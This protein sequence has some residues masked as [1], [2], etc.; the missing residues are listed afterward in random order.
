M[1][2]GLL[3]YLRDYDEGTLLCIPSLTFQSPQYPGGS[4]SE[5]PGPLKIGERKVDVLF[6]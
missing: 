2:Q 3:P 4:W 6:E 1:G 5:G